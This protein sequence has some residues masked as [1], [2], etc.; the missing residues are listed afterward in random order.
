MD[1]N[2]VNMPEADGLTRTKNC[3]TLCGWCWCR[4]SARGRGS[5]CWSGS[6]RRGP[7]WRPPP[8]QLREVPGHRAEDRRADPRRRRTWTSPRKSR[9][10]AQGLTILTE[11]DPRY[12]RMLARDSRP[13]GRLFI[14]GAAGAAGRLGRRHRRHAPRHAIRSAAGRAAGGQPGPGGLTITSGLARGI[15]AAAHRGA[16]EAGGRTVAVLGSGVL[17]IYPPEHG[18]WP[19]RWRPAGAVISEA[20]AAGR[21]LAGH[22]SAAEPA[23]SAACRWA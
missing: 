18:S 12:P 20:A 15:D 5:R 11:A 16:L 22:I 14:R 6:A 10:A 1:V 23:S 17:N 3:S 21:A 4:A 2:R 7:C 19:P 9:C 8:S 13:A